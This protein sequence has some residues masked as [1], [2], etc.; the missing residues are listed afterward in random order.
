MEIRQEPH[1]D[2]FERLYERNGKTYLFKQGCAD[3]RSYYINY[4]GDAPALRATTQFDMDRTNRNF[5]L[6]HYRY[7]NGSDAEQLVSANRV[8]AAEEG[9]N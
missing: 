3:S 8:R 2:Y 1:D 9:L 5:P 4:Q 6:D 7:T